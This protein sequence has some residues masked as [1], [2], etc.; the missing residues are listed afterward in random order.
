VREGDRPS[1]SLRSWS[2]ALL[3]EAALVKAWVG[4]MRVQGLARGDG[5]MGTVSARV[6]V[7]LPN[8]RIYMRGY[9]DGEESA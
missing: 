3:R 7:D 9:E 4:W 8:P 2:F 6:M 1:P 5:G